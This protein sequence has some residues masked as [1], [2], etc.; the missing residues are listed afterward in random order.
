METV[1]RL[2]E[3]LMF[4][5][6]RPL[7][8]GELVEATKQ[9]PQEIEQ[10]LAEL[11]EFYKP[12]GIN[13]VKVAGKWEFRTAEDLGEHLTIEKQVRRRL[14]RAAIETLAIVAYHQPITRAEIEEIRGVSISKGTLDI[15]LQEAWIRPKGRKQ[16]AGRPLTWGTTE[17]FLEDFGLESLDA[18]PGLEDLKASGIL[19]L[20]PGMLALSEIH[21]S[22]VPDQDN[23]QDDDW[24]EDVDEDEM[25]DESD[26]QLESI[27]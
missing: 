9:H 17:K 22:Q 15:L 11:T 5:S 8:M 7:E 27:T 20:R 21:P 1:H 3:A 13:I 26:F 4:A 14:S 24:E 10:A 12:R 2:I 16:V 23:E 25:E 19:E 6:A 18:L